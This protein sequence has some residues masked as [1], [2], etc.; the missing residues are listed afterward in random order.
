[1]SSQSQHIQHEGHR[2]FSQME[3]ATQQEVTDVVGFH[4]EKQSV[5]EISDG[6]FDVSFF[7]DHFL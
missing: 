5:Q 7:E 3:S 1:M 2:R 4:A 6:S